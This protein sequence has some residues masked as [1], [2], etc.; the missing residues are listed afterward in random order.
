MIISLI[1]RYLGRSISVGTLLVLGVLVALFIFIVLVDVLPDYGKGTFGLYALLKYIAL[2][3]PRKVYELFP[4][5]VFIGTLL[6]LSLLAVNSELV[7]IRAAGV[8]KGALVGSAM[9]TGALFMIVT[10]FL[11]EFVV[12]YAE[13]EAQTGRAE[14][15]AVGFHQKSSGLWLRDGTAFVNL[16]EVLPD[17]SLLRINIYEFTSNVRMRSQTFAERARFDGRQWRLEGVHRTHF[18]NSVIKTSTLDTDYWDAW[19]RPEVLEVF[20]IKPES[21]SMAQLFVYIQHL[22]K[23]GQEVGRYALALWQK[24]LLPLATAVMV[25]LAMPFV[26]HPVRSGGLAQRVFI[27][28]MVGIAFIVVARTV[29]YLGLIYGLAPLLGALAPLLVFLSLAIFLLYRTQ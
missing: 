6:G 23:N 28:I 12:P 15:L 1:D 3:Q 11:G 26:F 24:I 20:A 25:L 27:G 13:S 22:Q 10:V 18:E 8:S 21:L 14:A 17:R 7:A 4:V 2:S 29:G 9:K 16:G 19:L 5:A